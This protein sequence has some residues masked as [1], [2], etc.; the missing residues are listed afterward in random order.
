MRFRGG[1]HILK[2]MYPKVSTWTRSI[3]PHN[4]DAVAIGPHFVM[5]ADAATTPDCAP[6]MNQLASRFAAVMVAEIATRLRRGAVTREALI[7]GIGVAQQS[8]GRH[9]VTSTLTLAKWD[10][11]SV[12][13]ALIGNSPMVWETEAGLEVLVDPAFE[14]NEAAALERARERGQAGVDYPVAHAEVTGALP[15]SGG[16]RSAGQGAWVISDS[17]DATEAVNHIFFTTRPRLGLTRLAVMTDGAS[18]AAD[19]FEVVDYRQLLDR[20]ED[21]VLPLL[22]DKVDALELADRQRSRYPRLTYRD[23][24][25]IVVARF[26]PR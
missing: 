18:A 11:E 4:E 21:R 17:A 6:E 13:L 7:E 15:E 12:E 10:K 20:C 5:V 9:G 26:L 2:A 25:S 19:T 16:A 3:K 1:T 24:A 14:G 8:S 23:D 22:F